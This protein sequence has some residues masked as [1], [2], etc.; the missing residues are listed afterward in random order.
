MTTG[1]TNMSEQ[2]KFCNGFLHLAKLPVNNPETISSFENHQRY[3]VALIEHDYPGK[4]PAMWNAAYTHFGMDC[5]VAMMVGDPQKAQDILDILK[6]DSKYFGGGS[7]VGFKDEN[8]KYVD[9]LDPLANAIGSIN[10]IQKLPTGK[11]KGWNTDGIGYRQSLEKLLVEKGIALNG[12]KI[13]MLG[14]GGT[15]SAIALALAEKGARIAILNR[16]IEKAAELADRINDFVGERRAWAKGEDAI[17]EEIGDASVVI[18]VSTKGATGAFEEYSALAKAVLPATP[19]NVRENLEVAK[20]IFEVIPKS[21][22]LSDVVL[23]T[24]PSPFLKEAQARGYTTL[25]GVP[26]VVNQGVEA[27]IIIH[28]NELGAYLDLRSEVY[29]I[30]HKAANF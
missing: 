30:M 12:A 23:R 9:E 6:K 27:F 4:T 18:N 26:M 28:G 10:L 1:E 17:N 7:G 25:D 2:N 22:I 15:G 24:S 20:G 21:A 16:T 5:A 19:E 13:V 3:G 11:L 14:A 8:V 29:E